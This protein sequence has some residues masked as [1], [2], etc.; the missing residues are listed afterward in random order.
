MCAALSCVD[1]VDKKIFE[2]NIG[3]LRPGMLKHHGE[4]SAGRR[5]DAAKR[6]SGLVH[7]F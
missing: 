5:I 6:C 7:H 1:T 2:R 3:K 4:S